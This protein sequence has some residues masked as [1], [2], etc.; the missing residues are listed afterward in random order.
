[1][2]FKVL[3][4]SLKLPEKIQDSV[5]LS[6][7][8]VSRVLHWQ[9]V[10]LQWRTTCGV[11]FLL[12]KYVVITYIGLFVFLCKLRNALWNIFHDNTYHYHHQHLLLKAMPFRCSYLLH[13]C[14]PLHL[15]IFPTAHNLHHI[16]YSLPPRSSTSSFL[17][18]MYPSN[19]PS[20]FLINLLLSFVHAYL[21]TDLLVIVFP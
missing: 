13:F 20:M 8:F 7:Y 1:M 5:N 3:F 11:K 21:T 17:L 14:D 18:I 6:F 2:V 9:K 15:F 4:A 16:R 19:Y 10:V 12:H